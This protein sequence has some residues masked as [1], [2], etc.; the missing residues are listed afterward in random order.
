[1]FGES[2]GLCETVNRLQEWWN[3]YTMPVYNHWWQKERDSKPELFFIIYLLALR[4]KMPWSEMMSERCDG[5]S[6]IPLFALLAKMSS[7]ILLDEDLIGNLIIRPGSE[8]DSNVVR[9]PAREISIQAAYTKFGPVTYFSLRKNKREVLKVDKEVVCVVD[10]SSQNFSL[11][12]NIYP[13]RADD[14]TGSCRIVA[15]FGTDLI[16]IPLAWRKGML[17]F[18][19]VRLRWLLKRERFQITI[20][21]HADLEGYRINDQ[22]I[23]LK[24]GQRKILYVYPQ[25][26]LGSA[27]L[28]ILTDEGRT[29]H[30]RKKSGRRPINLSGWASD[31]Y[32]VFI[33]VVNIRHHIKQHPI[34]ADDAG[35]FSAQVKIPSE[36]GRISLL[37]RRFTQE[38]ELR[39]MREPGLAKFL[40]SDP[41]ATGNLRILIDR[42]AGIDPA[43]LLNYFEREFGFFSELIMVD[44]PYP[45]GLHGDIIVIP[46]GK[47]S[48]EQ[49]VRSDAL[50]VIPTPPD[51]S[52]DRMI[53]DE[54]CY[55]QG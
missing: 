19:D 41:A 10:K 28:S 24:R 16:T 50:L 49:P 25:K 14:F 52:L 9:T 11:L 43:K 47:S 35:Q 2:P 15:E 18:R 53:R 20:M 42:Q 30:E 48:N 21:A 26:G 3:R 38:Y 39:F 40:K 32:G 29:I 44:P 17:R 23:S 1:M 36:T 4:H 12:P 45:D 55:L 8:R 6:D 31:R 5:F 37:A 22:A 27:N 7:R 33:P 34:D 51:K 54:L 13:P 46:A